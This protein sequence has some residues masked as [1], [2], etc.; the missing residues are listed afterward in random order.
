MSRKH[1]THSE[2]GILH[3]LAISYLAIEA[4]QSN[5]HREE[6]S[7]KNIDPG[8]KSTGVRVDGA[9][10]A[11][12]LSGDLLSTRASTCTARSNASVKSKTGSSRR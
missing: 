12:H 10:S 7:V 2:H 6:I 8:S 4:I 11:W 5:G 1:T 3:I 9:E